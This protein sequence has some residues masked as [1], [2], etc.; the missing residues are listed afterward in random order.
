MSDKLSGAMRGKR[1]GRIRR[2]GRGNVGLDVGCWAGADGVVLLKEGLLL[3][4]DSAGS[5]DG[6]M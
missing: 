1:L 4:D 2:N 3:G 5:H 6:W